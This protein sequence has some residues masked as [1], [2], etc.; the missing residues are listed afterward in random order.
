MFVCP[1]LGFAVSANLGDHTPLSKKL[2]GEQHTRPMDDD[3]GVCLSVCLS[4]CSGGCMDFSAEMSG[5]A[6]APS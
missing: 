2:K 5:G 6:M 4:F 3:D 1:F